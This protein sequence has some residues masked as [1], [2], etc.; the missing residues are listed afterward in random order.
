MRIRKQ[1]LGENLAGVDLEQRL[2][3]LRRE[4]VEDGTWSLEEARAIGAQ[5][6]RG[7]WEQAKIREVGRG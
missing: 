7:E 1:Q 3:L 4:L 2:R 6:Q 5:R